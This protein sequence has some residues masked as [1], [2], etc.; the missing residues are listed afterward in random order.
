MRNSDLF[1][2]NIR[3]LWRFFLS[4][5]WLPIQC[6]A[7]HSLTR[8]TLNEDHNGPCNIKRLRCY[9]CFCLRTKII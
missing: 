6:L 4:V 3:H 7:A 9:Y 5:V 1:F 2:P 8:S